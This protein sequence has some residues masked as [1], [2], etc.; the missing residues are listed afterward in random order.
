MIKY[1]S[2]KPS[3]IEWLGDIPSH[4]DI[5]KIG[6]SFFERKEKV[7]DKDFA[8]LSVTKKGV[9]SQLIMLQNQMQEMI[10]KKF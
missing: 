9:V 7:S 5:K 6:Q 2:Y 8:P 3:G 1:D 4:W 10:E